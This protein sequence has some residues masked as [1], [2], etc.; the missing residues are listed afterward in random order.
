[1]VLEQNAEA[2][3]EDDMDEFVRGVAR[4][5]RARHEEDEVVGTRA[6]DIVGRI[7]GNNAHGTVVVIPWVSDDPGVQEAKDY[8]PPLHGCRVAKDAKYFH[9]WVTHYPGATQQVWTRVW[10]HTESPKQVL[11]H[12][13]RKVW[14]EHTPLS[15]CLGR[16]VKKGLCLLLDL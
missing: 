16:L 9:R 6:Q 5:R 8:L 4:A 2:I 10:T 13:L 12:L 11:Q 3:D 15:L 1:M 7:D 14:D